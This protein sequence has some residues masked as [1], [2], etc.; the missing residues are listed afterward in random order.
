[1]WHLGGKNTEPVSHDQQ[2]SWRSVVQSTLEGYGSQRSDQHLPPAPSHNPKD[3]CLKY[4]FLQGHCSFLRYNLQAQSSR[5][6]EL[7]KTIIFSFVYA[8]LVFSDRLR[9][10]RLCL[11]LLLI[12]C[13][14]KYYMYFIYDCQYYYLMNN[15]IKMLHQDI[16]M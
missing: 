14:N 6:T 8:P 15:L 9:A 2:W 13:C 1:M 7:R 5:R 11:C 16:L 3:S 10:L 12:A 4:F